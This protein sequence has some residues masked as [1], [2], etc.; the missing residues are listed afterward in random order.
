MTVLQSL[1][2]FL[3][4]LGV[5]V[6]VHELGHFWVARRLGVKVLRF[7]I[8]FGR[9]LWRSRLGA[10]DTELVVAVLP[11]GGYVKMLD[12]REGPVP[13][14]ERARA[15]N[16]QPV[17]TRIA[18]VAAGPLANFLF[19]VA[20]YWLM[21][22][23]G[24]SGLAPIVGEVVE[25]SPAARA[26]IEPGMRIVA[27]E[28]RPTPTWEAVLHE[29]MKRVLAGEPMRLRL[30][31]ADGGEREV[32]FDLG[33]FGVDDVG[34]GAF[35]DELGVRP[36]RP[37]LAPVIGEVAPG[38]PAARAGFEAG[39]R[40]LEVDGRPVA[41]WTE[42]V[43]YI[44]ERPGTPIAVTVERAGARVALEV[45]PERERGEDGEAIGRIGAMVAQEPI[46]GMPP[47]AIERYGPAAALGRA[48]AKTWDM[49]V[50]TVGILGKMLFGEAS[51][52]NLS[53]PISIAQYA[54]QSA[55]I[56]VSAFLAFLAIVSVSLGVL[57]LLP[58]PL[59]DGGHLMYYLIELVTRRPVSENV[60][61]FGQQ[62]G[63]VLLLGLMGLAFYNDLMRLL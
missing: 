44:R 8:G 48:L 34:R 33:R 56:G 52:R 18:V 37:H 6:T 17:G 40:V 62:V 31:G 39:D 57:N 42:W 28:E 15:F 9:P 27:V 38:S 19:A 13:A 16:V 25:G 46:G 29:S 32:V 35:L 10:D 24:V 50:F 3:V 63:I 61:A 43:R 7:S 51:V 1:A 2:A 45:V 55:S 14:A 54:G 20:A 12:E 26:G 53:G 59:L 11:L 23:V 21:F 49:S 4:A 36:L 5:L 22:V 47:T 41:D 30:A 58:I 60:Q